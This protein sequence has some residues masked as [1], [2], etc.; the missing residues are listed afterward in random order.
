MR[1]GC[2]RLPVQYVEKS[3]WD[4]RVMK[5]RNL[6]GLQQGA[7]AGSDGGKYMILKVQRRTIHR[8]IMTRV[9]RCR[10]SQALKVVEGTQLP[11]RK[12]NNFSRGQD[13]Y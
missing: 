6:G 5:V 2:C 10:G 7:A 13:H 8:I 9:S 12:P 11:P 4:G 3:Q 1:T